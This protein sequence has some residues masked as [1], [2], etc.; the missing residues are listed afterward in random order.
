VK[1][2]LLLSCAI[3][4]G[5]A[6]EPFPGI[7]LNLD[8]LKAKYQHTS[9]GKRLKPKQWPNGARVAVALSFDIDN[10][11]AILARAELRVLNR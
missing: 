5:M 2:A 9:F 8:E 10:A 7:K 1:S 4:A 6:Q 11:T 3:A